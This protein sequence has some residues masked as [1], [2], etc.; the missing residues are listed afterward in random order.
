MTSRFARA[1]QAKQTSDDKPEGTTHGRWSNI[2]LEPTPPASRNWSAWYFFAFQFSIAF[3]PTTYNIGSSLFAIGL[4]W[5]TIIAASFVG[6][7]LCCF[8]IFFNGRG[9]TL[10]H[11]GFPVYI[12]ISAGIYGSLWFI[13]IRAIVAVFYMGTQTYYASRMMDVSLS[14]I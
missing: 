6:T 13:F 14:C 2:D 3:S 10:Y 1:L 5:Q 11:V 9:A 7:A 12:R 4:T 8:I